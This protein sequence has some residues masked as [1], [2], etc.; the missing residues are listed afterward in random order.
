MCFGCSKELSHQNGSF[1]YSQH[2]FWLRNKKNDF[3]FSTLI[4]GP[5]LLLVY[6]IQIREH[7]FVVI[8]FFYYPS[9][10]NVLEAQ[11]N[12]LNEMGFF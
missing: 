1:E 6:Q 12:Q 8:F 9:Q 5:G 10:K 11:K 2:M 7:F 4:W 3:L